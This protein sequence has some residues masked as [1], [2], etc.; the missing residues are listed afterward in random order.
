MPHAGNVEVGTVGMFSS[1]TEQVVVCSSDPLLDLI[2]DVRHKYEYS[3]QLAWGLEVNL[4]QLGRRMWRATV[5]G[6]PLVPA[7]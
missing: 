5:D 1:F 4:Y 6:G 2:T 3:A 7:Q